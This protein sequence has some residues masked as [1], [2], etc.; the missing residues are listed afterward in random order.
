MPGYGYS[1]YIV[2]K[3]ELLKVFLKIH[4][5]VKL[6]FLRLCGVDLGVRENRSFK[7]VLAKEM[8]V[9]LE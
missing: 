6:C 8:G 2:E 3:E 5:K 7:K 4:I 9:E 1:L